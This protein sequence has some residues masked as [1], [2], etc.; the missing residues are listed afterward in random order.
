MMANRAYLCGFAHVL[1]MSWFLTQRARFS[2]KNMGYKKFFPVASG[3]GLNPRD[4]VS[5]PVKCLWR[6]LAFRANRSLL[7]VMYTK[8]QDGQRSDASRSNW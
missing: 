7:T 4:F 6:W 3:V 2:G 1:N 5:Y 8:V